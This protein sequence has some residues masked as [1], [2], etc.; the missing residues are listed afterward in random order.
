MYGE[1][2][3]PKDANLELT[4]INLPNADKINRAVCREQFSILYYRVKKDSSNGLSGGQIAAIVI[5]TIV[6][7][8]ILGFIGFFAYKIIKDKNKYKQLVSGA[9]SDALPEQL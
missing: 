2:G 9:I 5:G 3:S 6:G 7:V 8:A 1:L 4:L